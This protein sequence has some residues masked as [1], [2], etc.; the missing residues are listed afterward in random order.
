[1]TASLSADIRH[2]TFNTQLHYV[3][4]REFRVYSVE[5]DDEFAKAILIA[6][7][8]ETWMVEGFSEAFPNVGKQ[9]DIPIEDGEPMFPACGIFQADAMDRAPLKVV[10]E[11]W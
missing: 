4:N 2:L 8:G 1:M 9:M 3:V 10:Q 7:D 5:K 11:L 6:K